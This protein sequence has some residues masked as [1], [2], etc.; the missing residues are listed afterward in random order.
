MAPNPASVYA[1]EQNA[2]R[3]TIT[4][5]NGCMIA[6]ISFDVGGYYEEWAYYR[7]NHNVSYPK[8]GIVILKQKKNGRYKLYPYRGI[9]K[10]LFGM[11]WGEALW[12]DNISFITGL[13]DW[14]KK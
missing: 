11:G 2:M 14:Y 13:P 12:A 3:E 8:F 9:R 1:I 10:I 7:R 4:L 6:V 5:N